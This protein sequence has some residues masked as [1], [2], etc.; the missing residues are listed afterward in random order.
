MASSC[1]PAPAYI[2]YKGGYMQLNK[3]NVRSIQYTAH[4]EMRSFEKYVVQKTILD[5]IGTEYMDELPVDSLDLSEY[6]ILDLLDEIQ[7]RI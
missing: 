6:S 4:E 7:G 5:S 1:T 2:P 3:C